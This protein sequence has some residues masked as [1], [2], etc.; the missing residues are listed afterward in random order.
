MEP[1]HCALIVLSPRSHSFPLSPPLVL[2]SCLEELLKRS[3]ATVR[4]PE[5]RAE[6]HLQCGAGEYQSAGAERVGHFPKNIA[7]L[8]LIEVYSKQGM[9]DL[10][11]GEI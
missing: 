1:L 7:L 9:L 6:T 5:C 8:R 11:G 3:Y 2:Q 10:G 4:C